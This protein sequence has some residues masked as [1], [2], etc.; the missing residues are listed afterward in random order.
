MSHSL[1][2]VAL[3][4]SLSMLEPAIIAR[5]LFYYHVRFIPP[6]MNK[7]LIHAREVASVAATDFSLR[8]I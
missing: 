2:E 5:D 8:T 3:K 4:D 1:A 6:Q 7:Y